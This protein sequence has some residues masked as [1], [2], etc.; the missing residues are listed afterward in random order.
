MEETM[1]IHDMFFIKAK[2]S[3]KNW[4]CDGLFIPKDRTFIQTN[5]ETIKG[6]VAVKY[7]SLIPT[8]ITQYRDK[9][10]EKDNYNEGVFRSSKINCDIHDFSAECC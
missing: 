1:T 9:Y 8:T 10:I 6:P 7:G 3:Q 2:L 4:Q 5:G